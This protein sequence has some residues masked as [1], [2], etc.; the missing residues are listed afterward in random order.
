MCATTCICRFVVSPHCLPLCCRL[1]RELVTLFLGIGQQDLQLICISAPQ[2]RDLLFAAADKVGVCDAPDPLTCN[3][4]LKSE[5]HCK[6]SLLKCCTVAWCAGADPCRESRLGEP[7][8]A[9]DLSSWM[10]MY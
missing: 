3:D 8:E 4:L 9:A 1:Q 2:R 10:L 6:Y 5:L 7:C